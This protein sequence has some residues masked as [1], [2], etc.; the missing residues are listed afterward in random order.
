MS[1][2]ENGG[3][4]DDHNRALDDPRALTDELARGHPSAAASL[5][6]NLEE[7]LTV[8]RLGVRGRLKRTLG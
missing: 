8:T 3:S 4:R 1:P 7:T 6:E 5:R 2:P